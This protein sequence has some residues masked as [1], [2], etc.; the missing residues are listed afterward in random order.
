MSYLRFLFLMIVLNGCA[1]DTYFDPMRQ[2]DYGSITA[3]K[4]GVE[5]EAQIHG[6]NNTRQPENFDILASKYNSQGYRRGHLSIQYIPRDITSGK[7]NQGSCGIDCF[8][9][10][11]ISYRTVSDDGDVVCDSYRLLEDVQNENVLIISDFN[12]KTNE[13]RGSFT[14]TFIIVDGTDKCDPNAPDTIRFTNGQFHSK[15][16]R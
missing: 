14:A 1:D 11:Q 10:Y 13:F 9:P 7:L 8:S 6:A 16:T 5:W 12:S 15:I 2:L 4:N 3:L